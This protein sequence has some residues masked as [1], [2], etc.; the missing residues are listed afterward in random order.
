MCFVWISEQTAI[1][2]LY[3][4]NW[5]VFVTAEV[6]YQLLDTSTPFV[7]PFLYKIMQQHGGGARS[8]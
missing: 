2:S 8:T 3:S 4:I 1:I 6:A 5:L 7:R